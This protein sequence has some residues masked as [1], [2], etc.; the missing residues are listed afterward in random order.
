MWPGMARSM[1][2]WQGK[3]DERIKQTSMSDLT[4]KIISPAEDQIR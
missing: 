4:Q 3:D 2:G 1:Q